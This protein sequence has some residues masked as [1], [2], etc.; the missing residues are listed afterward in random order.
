M[1]LKQA[2]LHPELGV[3]AGSLLLGAVIILCIGYWGPMD[4]SVAYLLQLFV[5]G[6]LGFTL[7]EYLIHRFLFHYKAGKEKLGKFIFKIHGVHHRHPL[8]LSKYRTPLYSRPLIVI[9]LF[10]LFRTLGGPSVYGWLPGFLTGYA[11]YLFVH[12][13][14]HYCPIPNN[15][16]RI[17]WLNHDIHHYIN[18]R[19]AYGVSSP[20]WD[21]LIGTNPTK[22]D[23]DKWERIKNK[24]NRKAA[25][26][27]A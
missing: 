8:D 27:S 25:V 12:F 1:T 6:F 20:L 2:I 3:P 26:S 14:V 7:F 16:F 24:S 19:L 22:S 21:W 10:V 18:P 13:I 5:V 9:I 15:I 23:Y 11:F 17:V 4:Y